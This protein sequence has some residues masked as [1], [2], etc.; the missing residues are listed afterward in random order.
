[1]PA[2]RSREARRFVSQ[3]L[4]PTIGRRS[5]RGTCAARGRCRW[6]NAPV[7]DIRQ[8]R[9]RRALL[10]TTAGRRSGSRRT[11]RPASESGCGRSRGSAPSLRTRRNPGCRRARTRDR[12]PSSSYI[13]TNL[14]RV[15]LKATRAS[16]CSTTST[17][18]EPSLRTPLTKRSATCKRVGCGF[19]ARVASPWARAIS[20]IVR[21]TTSL[22][23]SS[24]NSTCMARNMGTSTPASM[25]RRSR[26]VRSAM[27]GV[28]RLWVLS[29]QL[30]ENWSSRRANW[31]SSRT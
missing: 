6:S 15:T 22:T 25:R 4:R 26:R 23:R 8:E 13:S 9:I 21:P 29:S 2:Q 3:G 24:P 28:F 16:S 14:Q 17:I 18:S 20:R 5:T 1:M 27:V 30:G 19:W 7:R 10:R 12:A 31:S 11:R